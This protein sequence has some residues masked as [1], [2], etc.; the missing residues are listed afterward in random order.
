MIK[1][2]HTLNARENIFLSVAKEHFNLTSERVHSEIVA[3]LDQ[4]CK[5][6]SSKNI[7]YQ[8]LR[9]SLTPQQDRKEIALIFD[10]EQ[11]GDNWYGKKIMDQIIPLL[12][13]DSSHSV[14]AGD[15]T[16]NSVRGREILSDALGCSIGPYSNQYF[17]VYI[18]NLTNEMVEVIDSGLANYNPYIKFIDTTYSSPFKIALSTM[19]C[20]DFI[21]HRNIII[22]GHEDDRDNEENINMIG[23]SFEENGFICKSIQ[24]MFYSLFL[25]YKIERPVFKGFDDDTEFCLNYA[26]K[27]PPL[28]KDLTIDIKEE[29]FLYLQKNKNESLLK[30]DIS[31]SD[32]FIRLISEK[33][34]HNYLYDIRFNEYDEMVFNVMIEANNFRIMVTLKHKPGTK[35]AYVVTAF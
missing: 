11:V 31:D 3:M 26:Q 16:N 32:K 8:D 12:N 30:S 10:S 14:L 6:L 34:S 17:I 7:E 1:S 23:Y 33:I 20:H 13:K 15:F 22:Q 9:S 25:S 19:L 2:L 24:G 35:S 21:K 29:K 5:A 28:L 27:N 18:N 4:C